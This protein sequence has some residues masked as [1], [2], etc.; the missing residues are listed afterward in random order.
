MKIKIYILIS[1]L[2]FSLSASAQVLQWQNLYNGSSNGEDAA[3]TTVVDNS[4]NVYVA[5]YCTIGANQDI[6][7]LKYNVAGTLLWF[8]T[9]NG[10]GNAHDRALKAALDPAGNLYITGY[11]NA[12]GSFYDMITM[13]INPTWGTI[14][15]NQRYNGTANLND[16]AYD[17]KVDLSSNVYITG[18]TTNLNTGYD[19]TTI[20]Y[21][22]SG[23]V[24]WIQKYNG[25]SN[26]NDEARALF[27]DQ[28]NNVYVTG[29]SRTG[30]TSST[31]DFVTIK[32]NSDGVIQWVQRFN[33][34]GN[35]DIASAIAVDQSGNVIVSGYSQVNGFYDF[36]FVK[37][38]SA[39]TV[40]WLNSYGGT[41]N[42]ND[43]L[44]AMVLDGAGNIY[45]TGTTNDVGLGGTNMTTI[46]YNPSGAQQWI[47]KYN[48]TGNANDSSTAI[49]IDAGN[50]VYI[51]GGSTG[52]G[53]NLD[54]TVIRY[55]S[56]GTQQWVQR[57][58]GFGNGNDEGK[59]IVVDNGY[60]VYI[61]GSLYS[62]TN[63]YDMV[64]IKYAQILIGIQNQEGEIPAKFSLYQNYPNPFNPV[65][66]IKIGVPTASEVKLIIYD[67]LGRE[68]TTLVN[69]QLQPGTYEV[70]WD[71]TNYPSG[72]YYYTLAA[73]DYSETKK[74]VLIK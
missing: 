26:N 5:G 36:T 44:S 66:N 72:V 33:P 68:V 65:T 22:S 13:K 9:Y 24:Q 51:T 52:L 34:Q 32:H 50:N 20:K 47:K 74:M 16:A 37:Y 3:T 71:G 6:V 67:N 57:T 30:T 29:Y 25:P 54:A 11:T 42:G 1:F 59:A 62:G 63:S 73:G 17:I 38:N 35:Q 7:V 61:A 31:E 41:A 2:I 23:I 43:Y 60:N 21:N 40:L 8:R 4:G 28:N 12:G 69:K 53:T 64:T 56:N 39:G 70:E 18:Y 58:N 45:I 48:G 46:K 19:Y 27:I 55:L 15:W 49:T 10:L 14:E